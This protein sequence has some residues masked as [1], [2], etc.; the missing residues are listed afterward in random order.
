MVQVYLYN[1]N[2]AD[3][4]SVCYNSINIKHHYR[5][6]VFAVVMHVCVLRQSQTSCIRFD[7][8][9]FDE[10]RRHFYADQPL[11]GHS[12]LHCSLDIV[13]CRTRWIHSYMPLRWLP[14]EGLQ[15]ST[16][17]SWWSALWTTRALHIKIFMLRSWNFEQPRLQMFL[18]VINNNN[19]QD[20]VCSAVIMTE[21]FWEFTGFIWWMRFGAIWRQSSDQASRLGP[22]VRL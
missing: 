17:V 15:A 8:A 10:S 6:F 20:N 5:W 16:K 13:N 12:P 11:N 22:R 1:D 21:S 19:T 14:R 3:A 4:W 2:F 18:T 9:A 7:S